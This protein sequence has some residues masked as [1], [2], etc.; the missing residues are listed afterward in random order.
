[1]FCVTGLNTSIVMR[2]ERLLNT[3]AHRI[4]CVPSM[5]EPDCGFD[6]PDCG[7]FVLAAGVLNP[8]PLLDQTR[9]QMMASVMV[10]LVNT[11]R[12]VEVIFARC[13]CSSIAVIGSQ[14]A[15]RGCFDPLY[16]ATKAGLHAYVR[17]Q[18]HAADQRLTCISP[19]VI[20][21]AGMTLRRHDY[22]AVLQVRRS[23][24]SLQVAQLIATFFSSPQRFD[25]KVIEL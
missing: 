13:L 9:A 21:D 1:L 16:A 7:L 15:E 12:L 2:L 19:P 14:S 11:M 23:V 20:A 8:K 5:L 24:T 4:E 22:P 6:F 18:H 10:N 17:R 25:R 3:A